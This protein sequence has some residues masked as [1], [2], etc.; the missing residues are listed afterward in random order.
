MDLCQKLNDHVRG[1]NESI[2]ELELL[3]L[4]L[5]RGLLQYLQPKHKAC[6]ELQGK[7]KYLHRNYF[8]QVANHLFSLRTHHFV[9]LE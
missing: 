3:Y 8:Y 2:L 5:H 4:C 1:N 6:K 9:L 7:Q